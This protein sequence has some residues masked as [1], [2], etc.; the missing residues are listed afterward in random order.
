VQMIA[1]TGVNFDD[2]AGCEGAKLELGEFER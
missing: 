2:V 1:Q